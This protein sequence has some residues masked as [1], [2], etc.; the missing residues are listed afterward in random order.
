[1]SS[2]FSLRPRPGSRPCREL[3][4]TFSDDCSERSIFSFLRN[5]FNFRGFDPDGVLTLELRSSIDAS[6]K[7]E[8]YAACQAS[9]DKLSNL[10]VPNH[11][12]AFPPEV[13]ITPDGVSPV[14]LYYQ[15]APHFARNP[16][17]A[18]FPP[19]PSRSTQSPLGSSPQQHLSSHPNISTSNKWDPLQTKN[20]PDSSLQKPLHPSIAEFVKETTKTGSN[21]KRP[22]K[23]VK[24]LND[25]SSPSQDSV[26][27]TS[28][29]LNI[30]SSPTQQTPQTA[31]APPQTPTNSDDHFTFDSL[32]ASS[33]KDANLQTSLLPMPDF[34]LLTGNILSILKSDPAFN[35]LQNETF[36]RLKQELH[37]IEDKHQ[38]QI[39]SISEQ[40]QQILDHFQII[41][42]RLDSLEK[43]QPPNTALSHGNSC[44]TAPTKHEVEETTIVVL[45]TNKVPINQISTSLQ[46]KDCPPE[47][48]LTTFKVKQN[49]LELKT[50]NKTQSTTL[51]NFLSHE[52]KDVRVEVKRPR[53]TRIILHRA[54]TFQQ[55]QIVA[56]FV[57][58][59]FDAEDI[60][61]IRPVNSKQKDISHWII[62]L[63]RFKAHDLLLKN[64]SS[65]KPN[66]IQIGFRRLFF[67]LFSMITRCQHCQSLGDHSSKFCPNTLICS[68]CGQN[69]LSENCQNAEF[70]VNCDSYNL[71]LSKNDNGNSSLRPP[72]HSADSS[73]CPT[74]QA[75]LQSLRIPNLATPHLSSTPPH[76][77][78]EP[79]VQAL[80]PNPH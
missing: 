29:S 13:T 24:P 65:N 78:D 74:Y 34:P 31:S 18:D 54:S 66:F 76:H 5:P 63:P 38:S 64:Y 16:P 37:L 61:F 53:R 47:V 19:L 7:E 48:V 22:G 14:Y 6:T 69:H 39:L 40:Q 26:E 3:T 41:H 68:R 46:S 33:K 67:K 71:E 77:L 15:L 80:R 73:L 51:Q 20:I 44:P 27:I 60:A 8:M 25:I 45:P 23:N 55:E 32:E 42:A 58:K 11:V 9:L 52:L 79:N 75:A 50:A 57:H 70:C 4:L 56:A 35:S 2:R 49:R 36:I 17:P 30:P 28:K 43:N 1:M 10:T 62:D 72:Y 12:Y 21:L 59:G